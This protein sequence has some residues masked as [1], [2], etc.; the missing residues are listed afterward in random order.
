MPLAANSRLGRDSLRTAPP[1]PEAHLHST[2]IC[3]PSLAYVGAMFDRVVDDETI[4]QCVHRSVRVDGGL[5]LVVLSLDACSMPSS[6]KDMVNTR[7]VGNYP[8]RSH[9]ALLS[10][11]YQSIE[12]HRLNSLQNASFP[13]TLNGLK[14]SCSSISVAVMSFCR[15]SSSVAT[16]SH[17]SAFAQHGKDCMCLVSRL[18]LVRLKVQ[19]VMLAAKLWPGPRSREELLVLGASLG[20]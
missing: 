9:P 14:C 15:F 12:T 17:V 16:R 18:A 11:Q 2:Q 6:P 4:L 1:P 8:H 19:A 20:A 7:D 3:L 10:P 5:T 13:F